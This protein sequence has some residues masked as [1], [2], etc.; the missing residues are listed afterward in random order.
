[1]ERHSSLEAWNLKYWVIGTPLFCRYSN[2]ANTPETAAS[3][4]IRLGFWTESASGSEVRPHL[5]GQQKRGW[6]LIAA[7][8]ESIDSPRK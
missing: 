3:I 4:P 1:M 5:P 2:N 7:Y 8:R 6:F